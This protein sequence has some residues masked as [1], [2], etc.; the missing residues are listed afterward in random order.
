MLMVPSGQ[1]I[2]ALRQRMGLSQR[3]FAKLLGVTMATICRWELERRLPRREHLIRL[4]ELLAK[5]N[6]KPHTANGHAKRR[7]AR[8]GVHA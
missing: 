3:A 5:A 2:V 1:E 8:N 6:G 4:D 7:A